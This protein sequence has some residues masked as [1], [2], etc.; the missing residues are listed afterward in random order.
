MLK[1][2]LE[3]LHLQIIS[4]ITSG[5]TKIFETRPCFDL[6][7]LLRGAPPHPQ[8]H[9]LAIPCGVKNAI[10]K[11]RRSLRR[12]GARWSGSTKFIDNLVE[13]LDKQPSYLLNATQ[14]LPLEPAI[15]SM[16]GTYL[17]GVKSED[18]VYRRP[19]AAPSAA[20]GSL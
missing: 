19:L 8:T 16:T 6:R 9:I 3:W 14:C 5:I 20:S 2:Q 12:G 10:A 17:Q 1:R 4:T 15:R 18:L 13:G 7:S 11:R